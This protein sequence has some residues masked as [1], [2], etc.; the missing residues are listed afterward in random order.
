MKILFSAN[1][2]PTPQYPLQSFIGELCREMTRQGHDVSVIVPQSVLSRLIHHIPIIPYYSED[3]IETPSGMRSVK[4]YQPKVIAPSN[5]GSLGFITRWVISKAVNRTAARLNAGFDVVYSHFW[6]NACNIVEFAEK[7]NLPLVVAT[8]EDKIFIGNLGGQELINKLKHMTAGVVCVSTKNKQESISLGLTEESKCIVLP[9]SVNEEK[10]HILNKTELR[11]KYGIQADDFVVAFCGRFN[12][13]KGV[14]RLT[15]AINQINDPNIKV[16]LMGMPIEGQKEM[17]SCKG[18]IHCGVVP[19]ETVAEYLNA[20]DVYVLP[21]LAEGCS[22]SIVEA[23]ACGL[24]IISSD[25]AFNYDILDSSNAILIDPA[26]VQQIEDA[27]VRLKADSSLLASMRQA[28]VEKAKQLMI[29]NRCAKI[30]QFIT[31]SLTL[32][33]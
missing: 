19:H 30:V 33:S 13:R 12:D 9:N 17:P 32:D 11:K 6:Q 25:M 27:I 4:I 29:S 5:G 16:I 7:A 26:N 15:E 22:N 8:G 3:V 21:T 24:P 20:A 2:Y 18:L 23:M 1:G 10:F 28:S 31:K 14:F